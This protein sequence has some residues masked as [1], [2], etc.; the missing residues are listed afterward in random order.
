MPAKQRNGKIVEEVSREIKRMVYCN[1][2]APGQKLVYQDLSKRLNTSV[3]PI[4]QALKFLE[5]SNLVRYEPNKGYYIAEITETEVRE[6]YQAR[7]A[8][9]IYS[10]PLI[11]KNLNREKMDSMCKTFEEYTSV[12]MPE[13]R[14]IL[15]LMDAKFHLKIMKFSGNQVICRILEEIFE[16]I[17]LKY[18]PEYLWEKRVEEATEEHRDLLKS[19]GKGSIKD[20]KVSIKNHIRKSM[21]HIV[22][23]LQTN[24]VSLL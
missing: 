20:S 19:L 3:T 8:L 1:I 10:I 14:R 17:Y 18:N 2:V 15:M 12:A 9:E 22:D 6:L 24:N 13:S 21:N 5:R 23:C 4:V 11:I 16:Q 7:E